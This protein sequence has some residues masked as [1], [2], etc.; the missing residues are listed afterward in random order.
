MSGEL[1]EPSDVE[2]GAPSSRVVV[3]DFTL[4]CSAVIVTSGGVGGNHD[5]VRRNWPGGPD[6]APA[7]MLSGVPDSTDGLML[8]VTE[9]AGGRVINPDRMWHYPE[10]VDQPLAGVVGARHPH[11]VRAEPAVAGRLRPPAAHP[12]VSRVRRPR[13]AAAHPGHRP[14]AFLVPAG[15]ADHRA[16]VQ[17]VRVRAEPR[18]RAEVGQAAADH[19][20]RRQDHPAGAGLPGQGRRLPDRTHRRRAGR[21]DER[22]GRRA[23]D[24]RRGSGDDGGT[25]G[26]SGQGRARQGPADHR[27]QRGA[28]VLRRQADAHR[29]RRTRCSTRPPV[30]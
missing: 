28:K 1:L 7:E 14:I 21:Q 18:L 20:G 10:G 8:G 30:R 3:G 22:P 29:R 15:P 6:A 23:A 27:G 9:R 5:L 24:R 2:R 11:P 26:R 19:Q 25:A 17:P 12:A 16:G 13:R 4:G